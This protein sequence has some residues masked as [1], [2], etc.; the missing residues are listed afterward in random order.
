METAPDIHEE[1]PT[2]L[3]KPK[4]TSKNI[5][6]FCLILLVTAC[7][8]LYV[9]TIPEKDKHKKSDQNLNSYERI[10]REQENRNRSFKVSVEPVK[11]RPAI[12][13][14]TLHIVFLRPPTLLESTVHPLVS[15]LQDSR[16]TIFEDCSSNT[17]KNNASF[18]YIKSFLQAE[19]KKYKAKDFDITVK[20]HPLGILRDLEKI[21]D[22]AALWGK[23]AFGVTKIKDAFAKGLKENNITVGDDD[24][25]M[26]LYFDDSFDYVDNPDERFYEHKKFRS[27]ADPDYGRAYVNIYNFSPLFSGTAVEII[28]HEL[29]HLFGA[30]DKYLEYSDTEACDERGLGEVH[31]KPL[32]PQ[33]TGD[34]MC[35]YVEKERGD[36]ERGKLVD[37]ELVINEITAEEIG[38]IK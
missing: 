23:D 16:K 12:G 35:L 27:F 13:K 33:T 34:I 29:L 22:F 7:A 15:T 19:A 28:T 2:P 5:L 8:T 14:H 17:C 32:Y 36:F 26:F 38:W 21:G 9:Y 10:Q 30:N 3:P 11:R 20:L 18:N 6:L 37:K 4:R 24:L 25:V 1:N 31:K